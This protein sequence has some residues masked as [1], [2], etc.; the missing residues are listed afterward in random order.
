MEQFIAIATVVAI[1][2]FFSTIAGRHMA[3]RK[4]RQLIASDQAK[5][6]K[7]P[8]RDGGGPA[9]EVRRITGGKLVK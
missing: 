9:P 5:P 3:E 4:V 8:K 2:T 7:R 6:A 1:S